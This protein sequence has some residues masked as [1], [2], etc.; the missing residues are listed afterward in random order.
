M[1]CSSSRCTNCKQCENKVGL[2]KPTADRA[3]ECFGYISQILQTAEECTELATELIKVG[4]DRGNRDN[5]LDEYIDVFYV[6]AP[7]MKLIMKDLGFTEEEIL[8][9]AARKLAKLEMILA[10]EGYGCM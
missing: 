1:N 4:N 9:H 7:Q 6:M 3:V 10:D 5:L 2:T 8:I